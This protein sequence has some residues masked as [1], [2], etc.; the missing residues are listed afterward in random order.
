MTYADEIRNKIYGEQC[1]ENTVTAAIYARVS[2]NKLE[3]QESCDNQVKY[4]MDYIYKHPNIKLVKIFIDEGISGKNDDNRPE[5]NEMIDMVKKGAI[6]VV[7]IKDYSRSNRSNNSFELEEI[8]FD[9]DATFINLAG[10]ERI[11]D[12]EDP[13]MTLAR[14]F[15]YLMDAKFVRDQ[16]RKAHLTQELRC[17]EKRL[18]SKDISFG[19]IWDKST[20]SILI[21]ESKV[22]AIQFIFEEFVYKNKNQADISIELRSKGIIR[23]SRSIGNILRDERYIGRFYINKKTSKL[24]MGKKQTK[25]IKLPRER[26]ILVER[27]DLQ[28]I[29]NALFD[30]AQALLRCRQTLYNPPENGP[31]Q[32]HYTGITKY[33]AKIFCACCNR[34]YHHEKSCAN[35]PTDIYRIK[36]HHECLNKMNRIDES[37][38]DA[39]VSRALQDSF[40]NRDEICEKITDSLIDSAKRL[41]NQNVQASLTKQIESL[42]NKIST[43]ILELSEGNLSPLVKKHI[44]NELQ[45]L[46]ERYDS[47]ESD[48]KKI[49]DLVEDT[50]VLEKK[51]A[52]LRSAL[53]ELTEF[54]SL[55]R[56]RI[57]IYVEQIIIHPSGDI[58]LF[59]KTGKTLRN[60]RFISQKKN[61]SANNDP[62][63]T[64]NLSVLY[65]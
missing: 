11:D 9:N 55:N 27:P 10:G 49:T 30:K 14:H 48:L 8:L 3:Q 20:K 62:V 65:S 26:W 41:N 40:D 36:N 6:Q 64:E 25:Y 18:T 13:D 34:P 7:I 44:E 16:S 46:S 35:I 42:K 60:L 63:M 56:E 24:G 28:L 57:L 39:I 5:Y 1:E 15:Q 61:Q 54:K 33:A 38:L 37:D 21:D 12:L 29:D 17:K 2:T 19:Y 51:I 22:A 52:E 31:M 50:S 47:L 4:A 45:K 32:A 53:D 59:L 23:C 43:L 58:D